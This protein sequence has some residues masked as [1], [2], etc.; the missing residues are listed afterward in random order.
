MCSR[1]YHDM[2]LDEGIQWD[3]VTAFT[4]IECLIVTMH[5]GGV[6]MTFLRHVSAGMKM[7]KEYI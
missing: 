4:N 2:Y 7:A 3:A 5:A 6:S 1:K